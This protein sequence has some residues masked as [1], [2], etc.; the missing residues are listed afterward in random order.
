MLIGERIGHFNMRGVGKR[1]AHKR[2]LAARIAAGKLRVAKQPGTAMA[3]DFIRQGFITV[4]ALARKP[5]SCRA[6]TARIRRKQ[7]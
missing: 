7:W 4:G 3:K 1:H 5:S 6:G 2:G